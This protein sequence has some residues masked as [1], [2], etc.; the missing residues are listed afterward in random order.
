[1]ALKADGE[2]CEKNWQ[3]LVGKDFLTA[4]GSQVHFGQCLSGVAV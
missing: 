4:L 1:M 3:P 2:D